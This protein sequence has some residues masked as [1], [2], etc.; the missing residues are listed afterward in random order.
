M[1]AISTGADTV[2]LARG[3]S[4]AADEADLDHDVAEAETGEIEDGAGLAGVVA[5]GGPPGEDHRQRDQRAP[6]RAQ[7]MAKVAQRSR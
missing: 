6:A 2:G 4:E 5:E 1:P 7:A 3:Q